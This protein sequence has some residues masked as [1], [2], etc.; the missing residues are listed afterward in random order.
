MPAMPLDPRLDKIRKLMALA[1]NNSNEEEARS[2]ALKAVQMM[3]D[4]ACTISLSQPQ[5]PPAPTQ[6]PQQPPFDAARNNYEEMLRNQYGGMRQDQ[7]AYG[8]GHDSAWWRAFWA[9]GR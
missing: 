2:A 3:T 1:L 6:M 7:Q 9:S 8:S 5:Q 4:L